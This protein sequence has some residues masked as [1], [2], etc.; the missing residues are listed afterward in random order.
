MGVLYPFEKDTISFG[1]YT[2]SQVSF[3][4]YFVSVTTT[5]EV[6]YGVTS[7]GVAPYFLP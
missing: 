3:S 7:Q 5:R 1:R 2:V 6:F 4:G